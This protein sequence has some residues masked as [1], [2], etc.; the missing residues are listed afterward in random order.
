MNLIEINDELYIKEKEIEYRFTHASGPGGQHV[1]KAATAVQLRFDIPNSTS[2]PKDVQERLITLGGNRV[3]RDGILILESSQ[4]RSQEK[5]RMAA[6][7][8][9]RALV[10][11]ASVPP[12]PRKP[13]QPSNVERQKRLQDKHHRSEKKKARRKVDPDLD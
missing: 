11:E 8:R 7:E 6:L 13:T 1:N 10:V 9:L 5:N 2:L 3:T 4:H 12:K